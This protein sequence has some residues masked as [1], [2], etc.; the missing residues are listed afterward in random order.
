MTWIL[1]E[2]WGVGF[3]GW[4]FLMASRFLI[5]LPFGAGLEDEGHVDGLT[6]TFIESCQEACTDINSPASSVAVHVRSVHSAVEK[7]DH[8]SEYGLL[9]RRKHFKPPQL[10]Q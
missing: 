2:D 4:P 8:V 1:R 5:G 7:A 9:L 6:N 10:P 3:G